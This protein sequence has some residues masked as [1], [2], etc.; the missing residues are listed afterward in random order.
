[1]KMKKFALRGL[2]VLAIV[3]ALC[4]F[5]SG[6]IRSLTT[7]K[8]RF[9]QAKMGKMEVE[10]ELKGKV[11][12]PETEELK[13]P[14]P[15]GLSLTVTRVRV[16]AG[17]QVKKGGTLLNAKV[18][19]AEKSL[20]NLQKE[21]TTVRKDLRTQERK[22]ENLRLTRGE[23]SWQAAWEKDDA[24]RAAVT[25]A[26]V[27]LQAALQQ[28]GLSLK[29]DGSLPK[30]AGDDIKELW[31]TWQET[32]KAAQ[33]AGTALAALDRYAIPEETWTAM[34]Q[35]KDNERKLAQ[36]E[37]QMTEIQVW[38]KTSEKITSPRAGYVAEI[39]LEKGATIDRDTV[40]LKLTAKDAPPVIR[41]DLSEVKQEVKPGMSLTLD[42]DTWGSTIVK[43]VNTGL[44]SDGH[45][46][47]D[48]E[49]TSD[50]IFALG[51]VSTMMKN[52]IKARLVTRSQDSTCLLPASA[53]RGSGKDRYVYVG[54]TESSTFGGSGMKVEKMKVTV[55]AESGS[56]ASVAE[57][58]TYEKVLYM[59][60]RTLT[61][62]GTVMEYSK[63]S[64][65]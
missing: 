3:V 28:A 31:N 35:K 19:D 1:M 58:L 14:L 53:V 7:P 33:E 44:S 17:D 41:V 52:E 56:T 8:V 11:V 34:Q 37:D 22:T 27:N 45:P 23:L 49:I 18:S 51:N 36:L 24:A 6:T 29:E 54:R 15:E 48:A 39:S 30:K 40:V 10:T 55:L 13:L 12:F 2:A 47:A 60:D 20:E 25:E 46:Y 32:Q 65:K 57:D 64:A 9:A 16:A 62:G 5:F 63:D 50:A 38:S 61:E 21:M 43:V 59:E 26:R 4:I 42:T